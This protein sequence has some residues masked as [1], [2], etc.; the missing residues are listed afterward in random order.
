MTMPLLIGG[1]TTSKVHTALRIDPAYDGPV[2][3]VLDAS[4][5]VGVASRSGLATPRARRSSRRPRPIMRRSATRA[6][7]R[8]Q[9]ELATLDEARANAFPCGSGRQ[10]AAAA[11]PGRARL[12]RLA[13]RA[14]CATRIDW[15]P[16]FRAW[17]LAG[18]YPAILDDAV[19]GE[20]ARSLF[21]DAQA[22]LD[23]IIAEN[24]LTGAAGRPVA[25][26]ARGRRRAR[27]RRQ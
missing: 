15:T 10:A 17:E 12:Q 8:G 21:A 11:A 23:K 22:M 24:W 19:V 7:A 3:H 6:P 2:V 25:L 20:S 18:N 16:F 27:P 9:S 5:A 14:I 13:A 4:R 26:P 1:A